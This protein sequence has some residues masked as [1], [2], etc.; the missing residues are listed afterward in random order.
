MSKRKM[1]LGDWSGDGH[2]ITNVFVVDIPEE[3]TAEVLGSNYRKNVLKLDINPEQFAYE[4]ED[5]S[6]P[7][8]VT[9][10]LK[11][12]GIEVDNDDYIEGSENFYI[13]GEVMVKVLMLLFGYGLDGFKYEVIS[14]N[15]PELVGPGSYGGPN[16]VGYGMYSN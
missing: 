9:E 4:Y 6:V 12:H 16:G 1:T 3:F 7:P 8:E 15:L 13:T 10:K 11:Q 5:N 14:E 2:N